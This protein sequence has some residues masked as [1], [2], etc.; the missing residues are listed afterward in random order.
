MGWV[1]ILSLVFSSAVSS[2][3]WLSVLFRLGLGFLSPLFLS[4]SP[5]SGVLGHILQGIRGCGILVGI[6][7]LPTMPL[8]LYALFL[9]SF[10][11]LFF[12]FTVIC[13]EQAGLR[14]K[15]IE[16]RGA[17]WFDLSPWSHSVLG[18]FFQCMNESL[19]CSQ[20]F[21]LYSNFIAQGVMLPIG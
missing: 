1:L 21:C 3:A 10:P 18:F 20:P 2:L 8:W 7:W 4:L 14:G 13:G 12:F 19:C 5:L 11:S 16:I 17:S 6:W 15:G 9:F